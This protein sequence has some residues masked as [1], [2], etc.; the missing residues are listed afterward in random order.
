M[1]VSAHIS[2]DNKTV[3]IKVDGRF[4]FSNQKEFR[5]SYRNNNSPGQSFLVELD[6]TEY[7]DSSALGMLLLLKEHAD[8]F[9]GKVI[10]KNP[11]KEIK[12]ILEMAHFNQQFEIN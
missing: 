11:S 9:K 12:K 8:N 3:T 1:S 7:M 6:R 2:S 4:D 5:D 10:I